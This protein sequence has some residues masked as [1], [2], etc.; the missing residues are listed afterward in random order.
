MA[1]T[2]N[3]YSSETLNDKDTTS[4][5]TTTKN[6]LAL[7]PLALNEYRA[8]PLD[9]HPDQTQTADDASFKNHFFVNEVWHRQDADG[10]EVVLG[11]LEN[12]PSYETYKLH[13][14]G[15]ETGKTSRFGK[16][17]INK[18]GVNYIV[19]NDGGLNTKA[20]I[21][22]T[23]G[24]GTSP[25]VMATPDFLA[26]KVAYQNAY[27]ANTTKFQITINAGTHGTRTFTMQDLPLTAKASSELFTYLGTEISAMALP[28]NTDVTL[29]LASINSEGTYTTAS[30]NAH[31]GKRETMWQI[32]NIQNE[33]DDT[34]DGVMYYIIL[35]ENWW[36]EATGDTD[37]TLGNL[38]PYTNTGSGD[39]NP[40]RQG[41]AANTTMVATG[42]TI[43]GQQGSNIGSGILDGVLP[44]GMYLNI[45]DVYISTPPQT[46]PPT[47]NK[48]VWINADGH[49]YKWKAQPTPPTP[50]ETASWAS[51]NPVVISIGTSGNHTSYATPADGTND[52]TAYIYPI[53]TLTCANKGNALV[54][55]KCS[56]VDHSD[57]SNVLASKTKDLDVNFTANNQ[58]KTIPIV[59]DAGDETTFNLRAFTLPFTPDQSISRY[60][61][62]L[63]VT[64]TDPTLASYPDA[65]GEIESNGTISTT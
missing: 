6:I 31:V 19:L 47:P 36:V 50:V 59:D 32:Y 44:A 33:T 37:K 35:D 5:G 56:V 49:P 30:I 15:S 52:R 7:Q 40:T 23:N 9:Q 38:I 64:S 1:A 61:V 34:D 20:W 65:T 46:D 25:I 27:Y 62:L 48:I 29:T 55:L 4:G 26:F 28:E 12:T 13:Q 18:N 45:P 43:R 22:F 14:D 8:N 2:A 21:G 24:T 3:K 54:S 10:N 60:D 39:P 57:Y 51:S 58:S 17:R 16:L 11:L 41:T 63:E 53:L 42:T